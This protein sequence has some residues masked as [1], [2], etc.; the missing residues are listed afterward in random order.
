[1]R[2]PTSPLADL[3]LE[4][5]AA[6]GPI[7]FRDF[8]ERALY[9]PEHGYYASGKAQTGRRGDFFTNVSV[10]PL[11][12]R[13][14]ARQLVEMWDRL[15]RPVPFTIVEQGAHSGELA[16]DLLTGLEE[17][18]GDCFAA[19]EYHLVEPISALR[20]SQSNRL[21]PFA[22][23]VRWF[24]GLSDLPRFTG[25]HLSNELVDAFP[26]HLMR[27][28]G[29]AWLECYVDFSGGALCLTDGHLSSGR[30]PSFLSALPELPPGYEL[31]INLAAL[32]WIEQLAAKL[33]RGFVLLVDYG[34]S[35]EEL[36]RP[37][38][39]GGTLSAYAAHQRESNPLARPGEVDLTA[40]VNFTA[41]ARGAISRGLRLHGFTDQHHFM[42]GLGRLHFPDQSDSSQLNSK[43]LRA[44]QTLMHPTLM[45]R[46]FK[47]LC[48]SRNVDPARLAG[49]Q[50]ARD[51]AESLGLPSV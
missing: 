3:L 13:L 35:Q 2:S 41:L 49:F 5:I 16:Q 21:A 6:H 10:G 46:A 22:Q 32:D 40:H 4:E 27:W 31:E 1:M 15:A 47:A 9:H 44:F 34:F 29:H 25:V 11:F 36:Y 33:Q 19:T 8:M 42:V 50:F 26:V 7:P 38:R 30:L 24:A 14:L 37:D 28:T 43:E 39:V 20:V 18:A 51:A 23:K 12:G 17:L 45:G 48:L